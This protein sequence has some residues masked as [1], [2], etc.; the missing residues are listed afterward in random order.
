MCGAGKYFLFRLPRAAQKLPKIVII[1]G[2]KAG[3][4][5]QVSIDMKAQEPGRETKKLSKLVSS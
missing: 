3:V 1:L 4:V 2:K 5:V